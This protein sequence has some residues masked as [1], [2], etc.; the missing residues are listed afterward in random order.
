MWLLRAPRTSKNCV[1]GA[2]RFA[3][4]GDHRAPTVVPAVG[5]GS[6][7]EYSWNIDAEGGGEVVLML[8]LLR[9]DPAE[10]LGERVVAN[11]LGLFNA[12]AIIP[13]SLGFVVQIKANHIFCFI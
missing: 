13:D 8:L 4:N 1:L 9:E 5:S 2:G 7:F 3:D 11:G 12:P 10:L 6:I